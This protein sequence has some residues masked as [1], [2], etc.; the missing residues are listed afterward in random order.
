MLPRAPSCRSL[1]GEMSSDPWAKVWWDWYATRS[2]LGL[3]GV[4]LALGPPLMLLCRSSGP[5][6]NGSDAMYA[7]HKNGRPYSAREIASIVRFSVEEVGCYTI[8]PSGT[9][10]IISGKGIFWW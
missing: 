6:L 5:R 7:V 9:F 3:S 1:S 8:R 10:G 2:H 4:A